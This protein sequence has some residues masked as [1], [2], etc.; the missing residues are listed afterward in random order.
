MESEAASPAPSGKNK[1]KIIVKA[2]LKD[3][4]E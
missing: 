4:L 3:P 1:R 2:I